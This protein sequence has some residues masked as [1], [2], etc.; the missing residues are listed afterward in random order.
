MQN[1]TKPNPTPQNNGIDLDLLTEKV[2]RLLLEDLRREQARG[3]K[4]LRGRLP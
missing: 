1:P 2:L 4:E 3:A